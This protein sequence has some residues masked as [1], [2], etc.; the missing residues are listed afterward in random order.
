MVCMTLSPGGKRIRT[1]GSAMRLDRRQRCRG[2]TPPD[3]GG[4]RR[5]L[6]PPLDNN[7]ILGPWVGGLEN[8]HIALG[9]SGHGLMQAPAV[10]RGLSELLLHGRYQSLDLSRLGYRRIL[11]G[12]PLRDEVPKP[13]AGHR[14]TPQR[15]SASNL[16]GRRDRG[17][18][19]LLD[20]G[21]CLASRN[22]RTDVTE[23]TCPVR[24]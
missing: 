5:L 6:G 12:I 24:C 1:V 17:R 7:A 8:F 11:D 2:V 10:G 21:D 19:L 16:P 22:G 23:G 14:R 13:C 4:E 15:R 3:P 9:F 20:G 18:D